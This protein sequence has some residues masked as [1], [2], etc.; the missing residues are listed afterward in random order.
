MYV[1]KHTPHATSCIAMHLNT[2]QTREMLNKVAFAAIT[3]MESKY[4]KYNC[5]STKVLHHKKSEYK[6]MLGAECRITTFYSK[7]ETPSSANKAFSL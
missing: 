5:I 3:K 6:D 7:I 1:Y 4:K 2:R